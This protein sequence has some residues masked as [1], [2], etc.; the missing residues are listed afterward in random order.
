[1]PTQ[2]IEAVLCLA[3]G[4]VALVLALVEGPDGSGLLLVGSLAAFVLG[5]QMI[6]PYRAQPRQTSFG[7]PATIALAAV[8]LIA[9][10]VIGLR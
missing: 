10:V 9:S 2:L 8:T 7:R 1:M 6:L 4:M 5:R 3:I